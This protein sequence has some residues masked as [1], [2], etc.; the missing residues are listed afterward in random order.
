MKLFAHGWSCLT[1]TAAHNRYMA[2]VIVRI[3]YANSATN[4]CITVLRRPQG[5]LNGFAARTKPGR[6]QAHIYNFATILVAL[7]GVSQIYVIAQFLIDRVCDLRRV[8][9]VYPEVAHALRESMR[10]LAE[11]LY[12]HPDLLYNNQTIWQAPTLANLAYP[13]TFAHSTQGATA[14]P[15]CS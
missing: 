10:L 4:I 8:W 11:E 5:A 13:T 9:H 15:G 7:L 3:R 2:E 1:R 6:N 12:P 14:R